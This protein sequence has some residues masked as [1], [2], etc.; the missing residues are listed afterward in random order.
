MKANGS[1]VSQRQY[2]RGLTLP[3]PST[4]DLLFSGKTDQETAEM[5]HLSRK[6][7]HL[8]RVRRNRLSHAFEDL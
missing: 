5:L 8:P 4:T 3:Q 6:P 7:A 2:K 1:A